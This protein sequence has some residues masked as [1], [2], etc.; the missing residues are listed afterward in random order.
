[1][2][3]TIKPRPTGDGVTRFRANLIRNMRE[4]RPVHVWGNETKIVP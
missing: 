4:S 3:F 1:M 2:T